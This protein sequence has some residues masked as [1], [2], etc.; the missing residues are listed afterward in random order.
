MINGFPTANPIIFSL[1]RPK[2]TLGGLIIIFFTFIFKSGL[3]Q[4]IGG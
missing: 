1:Y 3:L 2:D 4:F